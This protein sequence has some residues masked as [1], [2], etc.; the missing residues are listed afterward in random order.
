M[1]ET[2]IKL[3][4]NHARTAEIETALA[5]V[6]V[7][8]AKTSNAGEITQP[9]ASGTS[10]S[11][12]VTVLIQNDSPDPIRITFKGQTSQ[13]EELAACPTCIEYLPGSTPAYCPELGPL[14]RY[15][16]PPG[17]FDIVV[18]SI[19][20]INVK[21]WYGV[22]TLTEGNEYFRCFLLEKKSE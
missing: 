16:L 15:T 19:T 6:I 8:Q 11:G 18:E 3:Y 21:P 2:F 20:D 10:A 17:V 7:E 22:W 12:T 14:G 1:Y 5:R 13:V 9:E 4:P